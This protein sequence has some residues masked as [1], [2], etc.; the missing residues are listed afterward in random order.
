[1]TISAKEIKITGTH[2]I[3]Q[4]LE[5]GEEYTVTIIGEVVKEELR[6]AE[7]DGTLTKRFV[8]KIRPEDNV[9]IK[10]KR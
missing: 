9:Q 7:H 6:N 4:D 2:E 1:M 10:E 3:E 5:I 8:L